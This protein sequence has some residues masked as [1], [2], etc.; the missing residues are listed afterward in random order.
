[1]SGDLREWIVTVAA[2]E[3]F[4]VGEAICNALDTHLP[5]VRM[6]ENGAG[7][8]GVRPATPVVQPT[9]EGDAT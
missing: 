5:W 4:D 1:M 8:Y 6:V 9:Q 3:D 2:P 7:A